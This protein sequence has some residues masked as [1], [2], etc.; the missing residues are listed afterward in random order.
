M[1]TFRLRN[2]AAAG[3]ALVLSAGSLMLTGCGLGA[4]S[5]ANSAAAPLTLTGAHIH[6]KVH[7]GVYPIQGANIELWQ[8]TTG[9]WSTSTASYTPSFYGT[10]TNTGFIASTTSA[11]QGDSSGLAP[12][13][14]D[15][16]S[17]SLTC[18]PGNFL[19]LT[20]TG[21]GTLTSKTNSSVVQVAVIGQCP[22]TAKQTAYFNNVNVYL[23]ETST[24]AAAYALGN[25][26]S[27]D[28]DPTTNLQRVNISSSSS[29]T[30][31]GACTVTNNTMTCTAAGLAH[32]LTNAI[33]LVNFVTYDGSFPSGAAR[34]APS[35]N[36][37]ASVPQAM[38]NTIGNILQSCVD[39]GP[40][41]TSSPSSTCSTLFS[42]MPTNAAG[43]APTN[44]LQATLNLARY[45]TNSGSAKFSATLFALQTANSPFTPMMSQAPTA[46]SLEIFY[47]AAAVGDTT[48]T[49]PVDVALDAADNVYVAYMQGTTNGAVAELTAGG[50]KIFA[51]STPA[52][53]A[54]LTNP[55]TLAVD[56]S[57]YVWVTDDSALST[58]TSA[59]N[60]FGFNTSL[61]SVKTIG[62]Y[63]NMYTMPN[64]KASGIA[65]DASGNA[66]LTRDSTD[67][68][69]NDYFYSSGNYAFT[70]KGTLT[71]AN[72]LRAQVDSY[73]TFKAVGNK[74]F[75]TFAP[76]PCNQTGYVDSSVTL[77]T[78]GGFGLAVDNRSGNYNTFLPLN[79]ELA[80]AN[81]TA[82]GTA[83]CFTATTTINDY[84]GS[85]TNDSIPNAA[86]FDGSGNLFWSG[87]KGRLYTYLGAEGYET[88]TNGTL[89]GT[90][91]YFYPCYLGG[92]LSCTYV[93]GLAGMAADSSGALW[94]GATDSSGNAYLVQHLG[95]AQPSWPLLAYAQSGV[96]F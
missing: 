63:Y 81:V 25:F 82:K 7:G 87:T 40:S 62:S 68:N 29:N 6:G 61:T 60:A 30:A 70:Q 39:S 56:P 46:Y 75:L 53:T 36:A 48:F 64:G 43:T 31:T 42:D 50:T 9:T 86:A 8:S 23:S 27:I 79:K 2:L 26:L 77:D 54:S 10:S 84:A 5:G 18:T 92:A 96:T 95:M 22:A 20:T 33:N 12:G 3:A 21:G 38:I 58:T 55:G 89:N 69:I 52:N 17:Q 57:G 94:Y 76:L 19:Y 59:G 41:T 11:T 72:L 47:P 16:G 73:G 66:F 28:T 24:V 44:T 4:I 93:T 14:F 88:T 45:P 65:F 37:A 35:T 74:T 15:F 83:R 90:P 51:G 67:R 85:A 13:Y 49:S 71:G 91:T 78:T 34:S 1:S 32:G 80:T